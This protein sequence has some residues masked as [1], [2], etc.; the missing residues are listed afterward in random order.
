MS[1][2]AWKADH[3]LI[4]LIKNQGGAA[5]LWVRRPPSSVAGEVT[6]QGAAPVMYP[7]EDAVEAACEHAVDNMARTVGVK[8][9]S[10]QEASGSAG[11]VIHRASFDVG[12]DTRRRVAE[13]ASVLETVVHLPDATAY[14]LVVA[15]E[16]TCGPVPPAA[17]VSSRKGIRPAW[18]DA[19]PS[20]PGWIVAAASAR[21]QEITAPS[22]A[23]AD[24]AALEEL[25]RA[26]RVKLEG[27]RESTSR[28]GYEAGN[29]VIEVSRTSAHTVMRGARILA[30]WFDPKENEYHALAA[31]HRGCARALQ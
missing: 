13:R 9:A 17:G 23:A 10:R 29:T 6:G 24:K 4:P 15:S 11:I 21:A 30:R 18:L 28:G 26:V 2:L 3:A 1:Y 14:C 12:T 19:P 25:A 27:M 31:V 16:P 20:F 7:E 8:V 22:L 5:P